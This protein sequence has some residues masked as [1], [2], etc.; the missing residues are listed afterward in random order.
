MANRTMPMR[1]APS[2]TSYSNIKELNRGGSNSHVNFTQLNRPEIRHF[3]W[4]K[5]MIDKKTTLIY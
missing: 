2:E 1:T 5:M 4:L 3:K